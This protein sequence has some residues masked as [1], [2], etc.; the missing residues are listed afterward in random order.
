MCERDSRAAAFLDERSLDS[1]PPSLTE[2]RVIA[3]S[4]AGRFSGVTSTLIAVV[5]EI[6][7]YVPII[8]TGTHLSSAV[9]QASL[10]LALR[11]SRRGPRR[12]W[13]ARRNTEML[14]GLF[15]R[16]V[17]RYPLILVW[18]SA[19]QR[20]HTWF[21]RFLYR[22]MD[23]LIATTRKAA[24]FLEC[25][26]TV[27]CHGVN[28][29]AYHPPEDRDAERRDKALPGRRNLGIFG[30]VRP[31]KGTG[32]LVAALIEV[33]PRHPDWGVVIIGQTTEK[34]RGYERELINKVQAARLEERVRFIGFI[35]DFHEIPSWYRALDLVVCASRTEGFGVTCLEAMASG[36]PVVATEAGAWPDLVSEGED[37]WLAKPG[38][39]ADL[40][41]ALNLAFATDEKKFAAIGRRAREK[42]V[43]QFA[44][45]SEAAGI[46]GV[47]RKLFER[48][49]EPPISNVA[50]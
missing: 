33:L 1:T 20:W 26:A 6:A 24:G 45:E 38:D 21:T 42:V 49:G 11:V 14:A 17:L 47:Y 15:L 29:R 46:V 13:H 36:C 9:P 4:F 19:A 35:P 12:I 43:G 18:T 48:Y 10:R 39:P 50:P 8:A 34:H 28:V 22:R 27:V 5:P 40:A 2:V 16:H 41:R 30:R 31:Q 23:A 7:R 3:P 37:G 25:P 32:D 44:I